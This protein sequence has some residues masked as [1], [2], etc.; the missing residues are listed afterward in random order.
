MRSW[1]EDDPELKANGNLGEEDDDSKD[2]DDD[3]HTF[4]EANAS[5]NSTIEISQGYSHELRS[6]VWDAC[7]HIH[8]QDKWKQ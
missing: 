1:D 6:H 3:G 7:Y 5:L 4:F 8:G 2:D